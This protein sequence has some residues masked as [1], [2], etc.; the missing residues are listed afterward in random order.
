MSVERVSDTM[1]LFPSITPL[2]SISSVDVDMNVEVD[3][4]NVILKTIPEIPLIKIGD[5]N[6][7]EMRYIDYI[8][9]WK[10]LHQ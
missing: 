6:T 10:I 9:I 8:L 7:T 1:E 2:P 3:L 4:K 5:N